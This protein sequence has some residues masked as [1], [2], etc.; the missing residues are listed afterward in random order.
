MLQ[1]FRKF[2]STQQRILLSLPFQTPHVYCASYYPVQLACPLAN[3]L[4][5]LLP[6]FHHPFWWNSGMNECVGYINNHN[7][8]HSYL[9][10][11]AVQKISS[12]DSVGLGL[13][14]LDNHSLIDFSLNTIILLGFFVMKFFSRNIIA[15]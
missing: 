13:S 6:F 5:S 3:L 7:I 15:S 9:S 4:F 11:L 8:C 1:G 12:S 14:Y 2:L 10:I